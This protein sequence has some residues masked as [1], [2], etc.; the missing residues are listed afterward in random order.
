MN[1]QQIQ[2]AS[3]DELMEYFVAIGLAQYDAVLVV[4]TTK[5]NHLYEQMNKVRDE[6]KGRFGD[7]RGVLR[8]LL[9]HPNMQV[10]MMAANSLLALAPAEARKALESVRDSN[11]DPLNG[12]AASTLRALDEGVFVPN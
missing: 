4:N 7:Q 9:T 11:I 12:N 10:R 6:L 5:Y 3:N 8:P 2:K 1:S